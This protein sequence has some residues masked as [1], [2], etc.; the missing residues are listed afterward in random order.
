MGGSC[1]SVLF[2]YDFSTSNDFGQLG[3]N[4]GLSQFVELNG[5]DA[6][7]FLGVLVGAVHSVTS[8][9]HFGGLALEDR[10]VDSATNVELVQVAHEVSLVFFHFINSQLVHIAQQNLVVGNN[11]GVDFELHTTNKSVVNQLDLIVLLR[12]DSFSD[13]T[14][15]KEVDGLQTESVS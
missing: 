12:N 1:L 3:G 2:L 5:Q 8:A 11:D 14:N 7:H 13:G 4:G 15:L 9:S 6:N 10:V